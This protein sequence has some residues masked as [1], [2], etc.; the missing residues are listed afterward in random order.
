MTITQ[1]LQTLLNTKG[2]IRQ[3]II[4]KGVAVEENTPFDSYADKISQIAGGSGGGGSDTFSAELLLSNV[5]NSGLLE[6]EEQVVAETVSILE[7][8]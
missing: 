4:N 8:I 2:E 6:N 1:E 5:V 7:N 3:A